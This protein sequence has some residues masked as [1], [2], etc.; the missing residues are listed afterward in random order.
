[1]NLLWSEHI[2][3]FSF[4]RSY[5]GIILFFATNPA[6]EAFYDMQVCNLASCMDAKS[7]IH[8]HVFI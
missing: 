1:M 2:S 3:A 4:L 5:P 6:Y 8:M 7:R